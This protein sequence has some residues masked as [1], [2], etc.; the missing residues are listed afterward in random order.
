MSTI[1]KQEAPQ[2]RRAQRVRRAWCSSRH[3]SG[4]NLR[5]LFNHFY[6]TGYESYTQTRNNGHYVVQG[7][8]RS[9]NLVPIE[10]L[11]ATSY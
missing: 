6:V 3:F 2:L 7:H 4:E 11:Y 1:Q 8:S 9:P 10:S 5:W